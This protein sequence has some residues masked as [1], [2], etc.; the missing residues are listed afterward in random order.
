MTSGKDFIEPCETCKQ[1]FAYNKDLNYNMCDEC[2]TSISEKE[3]I[4]L[5]DRYQCEI[6]KLKF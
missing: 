2:L 3:L 6:C 4:D 5:P 1:V